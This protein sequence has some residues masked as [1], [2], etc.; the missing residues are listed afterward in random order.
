MHLGRFSEILMTKKKLFDE[1]NIVVVWEVTEHDR[2]VIESRGLSLEE[3]EHRLESNIDS[4]FHYSI[5]A[6]YVNPIYV[7][8]LSKLI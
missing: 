6:S 5:V 2:E 3:N 4:L 7:V 1:I 8:C